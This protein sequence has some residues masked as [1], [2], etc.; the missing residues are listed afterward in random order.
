MSE[1]KITILRAGESAPKDADR[2]RVLAGGPANEA[3]CFEDGAGTPEGG[4]VPSVMLICDRPA[5]GINGK[6]ARG[7]IYVEVTW[8]LLDMLRGAMLGAFGEPTSP[9]EIHTTPGSTSRPPG[10]GGTP[11]D[12]SS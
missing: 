8:Q 7:S 9:F 10:D 6:P 5:S 4:K 2:P 12:P 1:L 3:V 11:L